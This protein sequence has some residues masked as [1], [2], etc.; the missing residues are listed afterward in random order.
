M[1]FNIW[2]NGALIQNVYWKQ[3]DVLTKTMKDNKNRMIG[4][5]HLITCQL[6]I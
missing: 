3:I 4:K 2:N 6:G 1:T 5:G